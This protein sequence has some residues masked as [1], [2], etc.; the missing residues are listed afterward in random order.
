M[1]TTLFPEMTARCMVEP[2]GMCGQVVGCVSLW[3]VG[4]NPRTP[5]PFQHSG[6][7]TLQGGQ[8]SLA[9]LPHGLPVQ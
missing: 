2:S 7:L 8:D 5:L 9:L 1:P 3:R 4:T 6:A